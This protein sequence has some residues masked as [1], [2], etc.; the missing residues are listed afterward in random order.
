MN[1]YYYSEKEKSL[2]K[3]LYPITSTK[4]LAKRLGVKPKT[5]NNRA[6][7]W[8]IFKKNKW[9]APEV[10]FLIDNHLK[11]SPAEIAKT[12]KREIMSVKNKATKLHL[13]FRRWTK[14]E[15][16]HLRKVYRTGG[17]KAFH[18]KFPDKSFSTVS[19][20]ARTMRLHGTKWWSTT[21]VKFLKKNYTKIKHSALAKI[22]GK[23]RAAVDHKLTRL[24]LT[25]NNTSYLENDLKIY[26]NSQNIHFNVQVRIASYRVD[27]LLD[28]DVII[29][30]NGS[31]WHCDR[32]IFRKPINIKQRKVLI[33]DRRKYKLLRSK[34]Y[35]LIILWEKD[36][37]EDFSRVAKG[38]QA[39]LDGDI[40]EY[41]SAK[42]VKT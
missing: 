10:Q 7:Q 28:N 15:T 1:N 19:A 23:T 30:T 11:M 12:L 21:D 42:S 36:I 38:I 40:K 34:G 37:N 25:Q 39:V 32:R 33:K 41:N 18:A 3:K 31:Y 24:G 8:G 27:F 5:L 26:L 6:L 4:V 13:Y 35:R 2:I 22:L 20:K 14:E 17:F 16:D 29:E 9:L